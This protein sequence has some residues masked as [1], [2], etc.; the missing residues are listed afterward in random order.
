M[1]LVPTLVRV[2]SEDSPVYARVVRLVN[3]KRA[4]IAGFLG[5]VYP[6]LGHV[7]LRE[8]LRALAWFGVAV[9]TAALVVPDSAIEAARTGGLD[10]IIEASRNLPSNTVLALLLVRVVTAIDAVL[11]AL[12]LGP[13]TDD[14]SGELTCPNCGR[15]LDKDIEFCHWCTVRVDYPADDQ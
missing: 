13:T 14:E 10:A 5:M 15:E 8:W 7:Y 9:A 3:G 1:A 6:G 11:I 2:R 12:D 4:V